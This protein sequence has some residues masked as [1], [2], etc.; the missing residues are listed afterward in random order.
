MES[1]SELW[2]FWWSTGH[3][4]FSF[5]CYSCCLSPLPGFRFRVGGLEF[6]V[7]PHPL[8]VSTR[9]NVKVLGPAYI[10]SIPLSVAGGLTQLITLRIQLLKY[11][12]SKT[13]A[14]QIVAFGISCQRFKYS[15]YGTLG[16][17]PHYLTPWS[18]R[19]RHNHA[20][21]AANIFW[22]LAACNAK[23]LQV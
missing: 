3:V 17:M 4:G 5:L 13:K 9:D 20:K 14:I 23:R 10:P 12:H 8:I 18:I 2:E 11:W 1:C 19:G 16:L 15:E 6:R 22:P 21:N 7:G